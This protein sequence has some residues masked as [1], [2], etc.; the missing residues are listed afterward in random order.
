[1]NSRP[2]AT[3]QQL[4]REDKEF[5][6]KAAKSNLKEQTL[7]QLASE[8]AA[9][10]QVREYAEE[11]AR[12][13]KMMNQELLR[14]A[15]SKGVEF[16]GELAHLKQKAHGAMGG[17]AS[18]TGKSDTQSHVSGGSQNAGTTRNLPESTG[19]G[20]AMSGLGSSSTATAG[21]AG[22]QRQGAM[23]MMDDRDVRQLQQATGREFDERFVKTMVE[24][25]ENAVKLFEKAAKDAKDP[26][27]RS[28][29]SQHIGSLREHLQ[30]AQSLQRAVAE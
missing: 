24:E 8:K 29:A 19:A 27:V 12:E 28:F 15:Q 23:A 10:P 3:G 11:L 2:A 5:I 13:H 18:S 22:T 9:N 4:Q 16:E 30:Q 21:T 20:T 14:V 1:M 25:H 7:A 6:T 17:M 26:E